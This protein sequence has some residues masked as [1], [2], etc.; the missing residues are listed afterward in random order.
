M[1][2]F[3]LICRKSNNLEKHKL[4]KSSFIRGLQ[5]SKSLFLYKN[6]IELRDKLSPEKKAIFNRGTSVGIL[7]QKIFPNGID[8]TPQN[9]RD[10]ISAVN[11][12]QQLINSGTNVIYEAAFQSNGV[13]IILDI[14]VMKDDKWYAYEVKSSAKI[15]STYI[16]DAA[17]QYWV[18]NNSG[19]K[20]ED[21][22]I[23]N[24]N[25]SYVKTGKIDVKSLFK[26]TSVKKEVIAKQEKITN[27]IHQLLDVA[28]LTSMPEINIGEHCFSPYECDF[29]GFCWKNVPANS[30]F[31]IAG[32]SK[33]E[34]FN[35]YNSGVRML[36]DVP[37][38]NQLNEHANL[39][40][41]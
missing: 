39:Q 12:T 21:I 28:N 35:L 25:T 8:A 40:L 11:Y 7:A 2:G 31:E 37:K 16:N 32:I 34:Q 14:L 15:T 27:Q 18:I 23:I 19:L 36:S 4:S 3:S 41:N 17:L 29:K 20:L 38:N 33:V 1:K 6:H 30:V 13:L 9:R 10:Y 5:C 24:M 26:I 22:S